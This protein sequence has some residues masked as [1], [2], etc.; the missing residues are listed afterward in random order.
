MASKVDPNDPRKLTDFKLLSFD[1]YA[2]LIDEKAGLFNGLQHLL[3]RL[4]E[5]KKSQYLSNRASTL[6]KFQAHEHQIQKQHPNLSYPKILNLAYVYFS[7]EIFEE[8]GTLRTT[9]ALEDEAW[10]FSKSI[11]KWPA[12]SDTVAALHKLRKYYKLAI[13]SNIDEASIS[14]TIKNNMDIGWDAVYTAQKIGSYK[15]DLRN[16]EYLIK[17]VGEDLGVKKEEILHTAQSLRADHVPAKKMDMN[18]VWIDRGNEGQDYEKLKDE[19][20]YAWKFS[21]LGEMADAVEE[22]FETEGKKV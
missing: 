5:P 22:A 13:L 10:H 9:L 21:T 15:P 20:A 19:V 1:V 6:S 7:Y 18:G 3:S 12:F 8:R 17:H 14:D 11:P 16:F 2:T 4:P